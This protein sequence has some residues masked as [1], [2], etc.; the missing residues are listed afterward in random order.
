MS[1]CP[2]FT[3]AIAFHLFLLTC[4]RGAPTI[5]NT[6]TTE[7]NDIGQAPPKQGWTAQ[8]DGRGTFDIIWSCGFTM[9]ICSWSILCLN[10]P[11]PNDSR[12]KILRRKLYITAFGFLGPEFIFQ[13]ALGQWVSARNSVKAF[14]DS[15]YHQWTLSH[16]FFADMGGFVL[17]TR[18]MVPFP[19]DAKQLHFLVTQGYVKYPTVNEQVIKDK[20]KVDGLLRIITLGQIIWFVINM[21]GRAAQG[22]AITCGELTTAAFIVCSLGTTFSWFYK[23]AD[24][25]TREIIES[26][27]S[28]ADILVQAGDRASKPYSRTPLDFVSR[29]EW[30]WSLY[31]AHWMNILRRMHIVFAPTTRPVDRFENTLSLEL[32]P[33]ISWIPISVSGVYIALFLCGWNG[34]FPTQVEQALWR[35]ASLV[36][37]G[38]LV[39]YWSTT[40][41]T[42]TI[43]PAL[44]RRF[45]YPNPPAAAT[46]DPGNPQEQHQQGQ[47]RQEQHTPPKKDV[48]LVSKLKKML[49]RMRNNSLNHDPA[50]DVPLKANI[51]MYLMCIAYCY[52]R[53]YIF[54]ADVIQLRSLP[55]SAYQTVNWADFFPHVL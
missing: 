12:F 22:L 47:A 54:I 42:F 14:H 49:S 36:M 31:W 18:D 30:A 37:S 23:P 43:L 4:V 13:L 41:T 6:T 3:V 19:V 25:V 52:A 50:L 39:F 32:P 35:G 8:P 9:F 17:H 29:K 5:E 40:E 1:F 44:R 27:A 26:D 46:V 38:C 33:H 21:C 51:P 48:W 53:S 34:E 55:A 45:N 15:G 16:A 10:V 28:I 20:N 24:V 11:G 7:A 2:S